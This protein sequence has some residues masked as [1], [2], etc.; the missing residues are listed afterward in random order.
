MA[1]TATSLSLNYNSILTTTL[2]NVRGILYDNIFKQNVFFN[3]LHQRG[4]K[5]MVNGGERIQI[6]LQ[7]GTNSTVGSYSGLTLAPLGA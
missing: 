3:W 1:L 5:R 2:F 4:R 7:A 6:G